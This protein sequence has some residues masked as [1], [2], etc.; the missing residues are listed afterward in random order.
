MVALLAAARNFL[1]KTQFDML[2]LS[3]ERSLRMAYNSCTFD[4]KH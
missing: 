1:H 4:R 3:V 2:E